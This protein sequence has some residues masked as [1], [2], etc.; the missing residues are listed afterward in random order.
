MRD[1]GGRECDATVLDRLVTIT[2]ANHN[3]L[4][5]VSTDVVFF[6]CPLHPAS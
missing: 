4:I 5:A 1:A 2:A 3:G 6:P